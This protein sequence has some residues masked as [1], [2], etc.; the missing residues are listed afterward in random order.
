MHQTS[1][2]LGDLYE[3]I[4]R[5]LLYQKDNIFADFYWPRAYW[6]KRR[7]IRSR[8]TRSG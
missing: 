2:T 4:V 7:S 5:E 6:E 8:V 3:I 1:L